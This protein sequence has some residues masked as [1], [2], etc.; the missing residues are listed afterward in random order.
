[1]S[2]MSYRRALDQALLPLGF[3]REG[4]G[5]VRIRGDIWDCADLQKSWI[6]GSVTANLYAKDLATERI[7]NSIPCDFLLGAILPG[8]RIGDLI[9]GRDRWWKNDPN[10]PAE[11]AE[12]VRTHGL[13]W[14]DRI[15]S[16]EDQAEQWYF[17]SATARPWGMP[18]LAALA[19][20]LY[21]LGALDEALALFEAPVPKTAL[22]NL[23]TGGRCVEQWLRDRKSG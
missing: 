18:N 8:Q 10:G 9:D 1:M 4:R 17:R 2:R 3:A 16:L 22:S 23:V 15:Q 20:T 11:L 21:R 19:V 13:R 7:L 6:D 12:A 14:F 5:W